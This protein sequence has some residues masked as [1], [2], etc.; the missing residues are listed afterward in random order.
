MLSIVLLIR[1]AWS[2]AQL[3]FIDNSS[4]SKVP[5]VQV[6]DSWQSLPSFAMKGGLKVYWDVHDK[7]KGRNAAEATNHGFERLTLVNTYASRPGQ[8]GN[9]AKALR[10]GVLNPWVKPTYFEQVVKENIRRAGNR[11]TWV[12]DIEFSFENVSQAWLDPRIRASSGAQ[13]FEAFQQAYYKEWASWF[14]LPLKWT[15]EIHPGANVGIYGQQP[16]RRDYWGIAG[17]DTS[18]ID[19][20]HQSDADFWK[21]IDSFVDFY[22]ASVYVFYNDPGS[23]YYIAS[24]VEENHAAAKKYGSRP[25][26]AYTWMRYHSSKK[27]SGD[28]ELQPYLIEAIAIVPF[29]SGARGVALWGYEPDVSEDHGQPYAGM[30]IYIDSIRR[31]ASLSHLIGRGTLEEGTPAHV[32]W[33]QRRPLVRVIDV[34]KS[35]CIVMA[36]NPW[37][38][39]HEETIQKARCG[40]EEFDVKIRG[41]HI[42]IVYREQGKSREF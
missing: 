15:K 37:Q 7:S 17:G 12:H 25:V 6:G 29:F 39:D 26:Y 28:A 30:K 18:T 36:V 34:D 27:L 3:T 38:S 40:S 19:G 14:S 4:E 41:K 5:H 8:A 1:L 21:F 35:N 20:A 24:N 22:I 2:E 10:R 9:I 11:G 33:K 32:L 16:F 31:V 42:S 23:V 13:D